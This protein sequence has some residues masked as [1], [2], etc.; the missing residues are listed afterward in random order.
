FR[1]NG[2]ND[3]APQ[4]VDTGVG[5]TYSSPFLFDVGDVVSATYSGDAVLG[6]STGQAPLDVVPAS[7]GTTM[8]SSPNPVT[9]GGR[10]DVLIAAAN[11]DTALAPFGSVQVSIDG[12]P[13]GPALELDENGQVAVELEADVPAGDY[14]VRADYLDD[15]AQIADFRPS[16]A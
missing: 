3:G 8:V 2:E 9:S 11:T 7:T 12:A 1:L 15:T 5:A 4:A 14:T 6:W 16:S 10:L 13:V